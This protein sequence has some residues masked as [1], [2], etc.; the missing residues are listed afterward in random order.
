MFGV[1]YIP[2]FPTMFKTMALTAKDC[3]LVVAV[4]SSVLILD[5]LSKVIERAFRR[6]RI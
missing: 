4:A 2:F 1:L 3:I 5:E 6:R